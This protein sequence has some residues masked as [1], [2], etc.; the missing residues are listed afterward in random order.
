[1]FVTIHRILPISARSWQYMCDHNCHRLSILFLR[2]ERIAT[3]GLQNIKIRFL[4]VDY[5][6]WEFFRELQ[7]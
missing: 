6:L 4:K 5:Y 7:L 2:N 3:S 1:M